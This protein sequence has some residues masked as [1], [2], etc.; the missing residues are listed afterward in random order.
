[1]DDELVEFSKEYAIKNLANL[2]TEFDYELEKFYQFL[3]FPKFSKKN[4]IGLGGGFSAG[5]SSFINSFFNRKI[6]LRPRVGFSLK[7]SH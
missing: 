2:M 6:L 7:S 4:T 5:K 1:M 3:R